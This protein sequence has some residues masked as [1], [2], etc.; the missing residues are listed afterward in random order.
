ME[1][2]VDNEQCVSIFGYDRMTHA[3]RDLLPHAWVLPLETKSVL[4][5]AHRVQTSD[6]LTFE[7]PGLPSARQ[8]SGRCGVIVG[9]RRTLA[10]TR[11]DVPPILMGRVVVTDI[12]IP[13]ISGGGI[14]H[15]FIGLYAPWDPGIDNISLTEFWRSVRDL[16]QQARSWT[17]IGDFNAT[18]SAAESSNPT[19]YIS[20]NSRAF[21]AFLPTIDGLDAWSLSPERHY[22]TDY[23]CHAGSGHSLI[24]RVLFSHS[25]VL[26]GEITLAPYYVGATDHRPIEARIFLNSSPVLSHSPMPS[27]NSA[28]RHY[29]P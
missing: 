27:Q 5:V 14:P 19:A 6:Y 29:Y 18:V 24:D 7:S 16:T 23:T 2:T 17:I 8:R 1:K 10:S 15:R 11:I 4:P 3:L 28:P 9:V 25:G 12:I 21:Q 22:L 26:H 13:T 20:T